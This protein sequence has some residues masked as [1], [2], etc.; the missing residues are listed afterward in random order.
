M[1]PEAPGPC[2]GGLSD[3]FDVA[4]AEAVEAAVHQLSSCA[5]AVPEFYLQALEEMIAGFLRSAADV[6][7]MVSIP[8][9][10]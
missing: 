3:C 4:A 5:Q 2:G 8:S 10:N 9:M 1:T 7:Q 6:E